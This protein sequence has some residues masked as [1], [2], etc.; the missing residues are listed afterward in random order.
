MSKRNRLDRRSNKMRFGGLPHQVFEHPDYQALGG[1]AVKLLMDFACQYNGRNNGD[2]SAAYS[3]LKDRGW[4][5]R[6][7]ISDA[8]NEL[9]ERNIITR[10][11]EGRFQN[12]GATCALYAL[13]WYP[14]DECHGKLDVAPTRVPPR[15]FSA[16]LSPTPSPKNGPGSIQDLGRVRV[17]DAKGRFL[18]VQKADRDVDAA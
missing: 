3:Q 7:T 18:S 16:E 14:I 11:R 4:K 12:P 6:S 1:S 17:R 5:S 2:L 15:A 9:L 10:T 13:N 8:V